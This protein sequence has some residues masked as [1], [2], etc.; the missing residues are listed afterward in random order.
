[1]YKV[2]VFAGTT[3]GYGLCR[4]LGENQIPVLGCVAT[5]YGAKSLQ[6]GEFL[7]VRAGR[8]TRPEME[9]LL[10]RERPQL[11][12]DAT[13]PYAA[14]VTENIR[15]ACS[16]TEI[17]CI[18][19]LRNDSEHQQAV[20]VESTEAAVR[21][22][23]ETEGKVLLTTGSKELKAFTEIPDYQKRI[24]ARVLSLP[25]VIE[26]CRELGFEGKNLIAMQGP[27]SE[28]MNR[29]MLRQYDCRYLVTKD[30]G[31]AGGYRNFS[32]SVQTY[33][34][35][36]IWFYIQAPRYPSGNWHGKPG[37]PY[38]SGK[39]D[40]GKSRS[41]YRGKKNGRCRAPFSSGCFL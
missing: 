10:K 16:N 12:L 15:T 20:Y 13:H 39:R 29:A 2:I 31:K 23:K 41:Y 30:S 3:E 21:Y 22:L 7:H 27:F 17:S 25:S 38:H 8:L 36:K 40:C 32:R 33:A 35:R 11:V 5:E 26:A 19:V 1:M 24:F 18:R 28:E 9:E 4:F 14:E 37:N 6:E 34:G